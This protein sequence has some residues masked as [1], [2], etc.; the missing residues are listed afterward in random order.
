[1]LAE[2]PSFSV[3]DRKHTYLNMCKHRDKLNCRFHIN[4]NILLKCHSVEYA[5]MSHMYAYNIALKRVLFI[6]SPS[7][8][9]KRELKEWAD[10]HTQP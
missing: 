8:S 10:Y 6:A 3:F 7:H 2:T 9:C 1:M 4:G 5:Y